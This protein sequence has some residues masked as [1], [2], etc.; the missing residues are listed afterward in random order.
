VATPAV[1]AQPWTDRRRRADAL[2]G[3]YPFAAEVLALYGELLDIQERVY[4]AALTDSPD[5][6]RL[7]EYV[8]GRVV[9]L[10]VNVTVSH[11]PEALSRAIGQHVRG[12]D[13]AEVV[14]AWLAGSELPPLDSY[15]ARAA[16]GP[17]LE[18]L[19]P[20]AGDACPGSRDERHCP[21]CGG[22]PQVSYFALSADALVASHRYLVCSR[23]AACW[24]YPR[25]TCAACGE[26]ASAKLAVYAE[27][28]T[29]AAETSGHLVRG[30]AAA[31]LDDRGSDAP[32]NAARFPHIRVE[33]CETC[34]RYLLGIDLM[35]D[36]RAVPIVDEMAALPL[37]LYAQERGMAKIVPN[38]MGV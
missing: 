37:D 20:R 25:L 12:V 30:V 35:R 5:P 22:A 2:R 7:A 6:G 10:V 21:V 24:P 29:A 1:T 36:V 9:P 32:G 3:R 33:A 18:A 8:A 34:S 16:T 11:G 26:H 13:P 23:C 15:L 38:L 19:G 14:A 27:E 31:R 28:Q 4:L 17:V